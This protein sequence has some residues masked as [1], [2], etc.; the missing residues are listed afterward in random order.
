[1]ATWAPASTICCLI[2]RWKLFK[3]IKLKLREDIEKAFAQRRKP[4]RLIEFRDPITP[5][6]KDALWF[7]N[8]DWREIT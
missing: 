6:Q 4:S 1:M 5:E 7:D 8:R 2:K 3:V